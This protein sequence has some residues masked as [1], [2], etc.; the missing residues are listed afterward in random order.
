[1]SNR[2]DPDQVPHNVGNSRCLNATD[3]GL[4]SK[5]LLLLS[6]KLSCVLSAVVF[7][8]QPGSRI[9]SDIISSLI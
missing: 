8:K 3:M 2:S 6:W 4:D 7:V 5:I 9:R 1:M